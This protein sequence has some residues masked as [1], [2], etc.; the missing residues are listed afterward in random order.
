MRGWKIRAGGYRWCG[1]EKWK[2][3]SMGRGR[4]GGRCRRTEGGEMQQRGKR[5]RRLWV[6]RAGGE[7]RERQAGWGGKGV[8]WQQCG[9]R[10]KAGAEG[11]QGRGKG[12]VGGGEQ[13]GGAAKVRGR[14][15]GKPG[16]GGKAGA[17]E[18]ARGRGK[19]VMAGRRRRGKAG[20]ERP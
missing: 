11:M 16:A 3:G 7:R 18:E 15:R 8:E 12:R 14:K 17:G 6:A 13:G 5:P 4:G 20:W 9:R 10:G 2:A 1:G 19:G